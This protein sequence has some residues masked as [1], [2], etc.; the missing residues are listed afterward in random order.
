MFLCPRSD[1]TLFSFQNFLSP[2]A[3]RLLGQRLQGFC[4]DERTQLRT[5]RM[6]HRKTAKPTKLRRDLRI[7][8]LRLDD[9]RRMPVRYMLRLQSRLFLVKL[10]KQ[11]ND[12]T[13]ENFRISNLCKL[14][15]DFGPAEGWLVRL[16]LRYAPGEG[17][18]PK[19]VI[20]PCFGFIERSRSFSRSRGSQV[21]VQSFLTLA[22]FNTSLMLLF[23]LVNI[24]SLLTIA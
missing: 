20:K 15:L 5:V 21:K 18:G 19:G 23:K 1:K 10:V 22:K 13:A 9:S 7:R 2:D 3:T 6:R 16:D 12:F 24:Y 14:N 8:Y 17:I 4:R 11:S